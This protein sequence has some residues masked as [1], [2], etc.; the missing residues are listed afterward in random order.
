M[1][2]NESPETWSRLP[3]S[4][5]VC[6]CGP[7]GITRCIYGTA[8]LPGCR[9]SGPAGGMSSGAVPA[10]GAEL[11][12]RCPK[13]SSSRANAD[14]SS[15]VSP[16]HLERGNARLAP[17]GHRSVGRLAR[18]P[19]GYCREGSPRARV[20]APIAARSPQRW[21]VCHRGKACCG[22]RATPG[23]ISV[24]SSCAWPGSAPGYRNRSNDRCVAWP[25]VERTGPVA[26]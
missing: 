19:V 10:A 11:P 3:R 15:R 6:R 1:N 16:A 12:P 21:S 8:R 2:R 18:A 25:I 14:G 13:A 24:D 17:G 7:P 4:T 5:A 20:V 9:W 22:F 26:V 23:R